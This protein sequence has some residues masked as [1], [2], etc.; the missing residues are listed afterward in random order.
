M[1]KI[2]LRGRARRLVC[3]A[4]LLSACVVGLAAGW[5][6]LGASAGG[7]S[8]KAAAASARQT[9]LEWI[10]LSVMRSFVRGASARLSGVPSA[11]GG[12]LRL[13]ALRLPQPSTQ[14]ASARTYVVWASGGGSV[15]RVGELVVD[16]RG[17]GGLEFERPAPFDRYTVI[18]TAEPSATADRP[19]GAPV[20]STKANEVRALYPSASTNVAPA[21]A[22]QQTRPRQ[23]RAQEKFTRAYPSRG[24]DFYSEVDDAL[25]ANG[26]GR[27]LELVGTET[28]PGAGG[29]A[30]ATT[31]TGNAY[32]RVRF[33]DL[34]LPSAIGADTYVL[35]G[36]QPG[37][38][39]VYMGSLPT[40]ADL[41]HAHTYVRTGGFGGDDY[42]LAVTAERQ[43]PVPRPSDRRTLV[44]R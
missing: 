38:R 27:A 3:A 15:V 4:L 7:G 25:D 9:T 26:G 37:G 10:V 1:K 5:R 36:I 17:N 32:V 18:V 23:Q 39:I 42:E 35:W 31:R 21:R 14:G 33:R 11:S 30:R 6:G 24:G 8:K 43:R 29:T 44:S 2:V 16:E 13:T 41:N 12:R 22:E 40:T 28:T 20:L 19:A 34:P